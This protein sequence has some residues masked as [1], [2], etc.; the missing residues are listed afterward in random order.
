MRVIWTPEADFDRADIIAYIRADN[1][2]AA[3]R[4]QELFNRAAE[5]LADHPELGRPGK[6]PVPAS[7]SPT[8]AI[9]W[10][11]RSRPGPSGF[12]HW[13]I[14]PGSGRQPST[15]R[16]DCQ[17]LPGGGHSHTRGLTSVG[18]ALEI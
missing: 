10:S 12:W 18:Q 16:N 1:P 11:T 14:P 4:V 7:C 2:G 8:R 5:R 13:P 9:A 15:G 6:T 17:P 3:A